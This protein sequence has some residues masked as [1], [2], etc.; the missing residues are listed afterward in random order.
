MYTQRTDSSGANRKIKIAV[1]LAGIFFP[2]GILFRTMH[3]PG[4]NK[5]LFA[6]FIIILF[7]VL[8]FMWVSIKQKTN[9]IKERRMFLFGIISL[10]IFITATALKMFHLPMAGIA[11]S[12]GSI[13]LVTIFLPLYSYN[14]FTKTNKISAQFIYIIIASVYVATMVM[15]MSFGSQL[16]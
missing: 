2:V 8:P 4:A 12:V 13:F 6:A 11:L 1:F 15:L 9:D 3:W 16:S 7:A 14:E 10:G 5:L